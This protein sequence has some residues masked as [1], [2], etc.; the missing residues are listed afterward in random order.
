MNIQGINGSDLQF[1]SFKPQ[2]SLEAIKAATKNNGHQEA[3]IENEQGLHVV[4]GGKVEIDREYADAD[5]QLHVTSL[6]TPGRFPWTGSKVNFGELKGTLV[7]VDHETTKA[8]PE[9]GQ[10]IGAWI[11]GFAGFVGGGVIAPNDFNA[12]IVVGVGILIG[13][14]IGSAIGE[15]VATTR[16]DDRAIKQL[17]QPVVA[18]VLPTRSLAPA[19]AAAK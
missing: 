15:K 10:D 4:Y 8:S 13:A 16:P 9:K 19:Q 7:L 12:L 14:A 1:R 17:A 11:G 5:G 18:T 2:T 6:E 3:I